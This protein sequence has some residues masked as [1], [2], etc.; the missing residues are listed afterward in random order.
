MGYVLRRLVAFALTLSIAFT[1]A[2]LASAEP[3]TGA[4]TGSVTASD[5]TPIARASV[6]LQGRTSRTQR[7]DQSGRFS[8]EG[9]APGM[10]A[11][12]AGAGEYNPLAP[13]PIEVRAGAPKSIE[14][15]LV[16]S[17]TSLVT[18][19]TVRAA[20][21]TAIST[22]S[23][24]T[25][26]LNTQE[27]AARGFTRIGDVLQDAL[28]ATVIRQGSSSLA[29][30]QSVALRGPDPTETLIDIDGHEV[31]NSSTGDFD[32]ALLDPAD[33]E[34]VQ[35]VYGIAP[36]SLIAPSTIGGAINV[37]TL[38]PTL[39]RHG[40]LRLS[41][42]SFNSFGET[43][44]ETGTINRLGYALSVHRTTTANEV[45]RTM[46]SDPNANM[47][48]V[49]SSVD[50]GTA[51][52]KLR[53]RFGKSGDGYAEFTLRDQS[54]VRD[55]S[56]ALSSIVLPGQAVPGP[57][58]LAAAPPV[59]NS[60]AGSM[61]LDRNA[62]YGFDVQVPLGSHGSEGTARTTALLRHLTSV[63][64]RSVVGPADGLSPYYYNSHDRLSDDTLEIDHNRTNATFALKFRL[65]SERLDTESPATAVPNALSR[66]AQ[67]QGSAALRFTYDPTTHMHYTAAAYYSSFSTFGQSFDPRLGI[68]WTPTA[69]TALRASA[70]T[71]FQAPQLSELFV[72]Q[73][74]PQPDANGHVNIG[75]PNLKADR[76]NEYDIGI[77][78]LFGGPAH[79]THVAADMYR[80]NLRTPSQRF[81]PASTC[82]QG[83]PDLS[84]ASYPI[85]IGNAVYTG[86]ELHVDQMLDPQTVVRVGYGVDSA[87][88]KS[89]PPQ[90]QD[91]TIVPHEQFL[92]VPLHKATL[93]I[94]HRVR[95]G[96]SYNA[97]L[98]YEGRYNELNQPPFTTLRAGLN[99][100]FA[101]NDIGLE[102][103]NITG[104]YN[105][106]FTRGGAGVPYG[107]A[108]GSIATD[109][110]PLQGPAF[111][112]SLTRRF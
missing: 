5:G 88:P 92:G 24:P 112:L 2:R 107:G 38:E 51:L 95:S 86:G 96:I 102:A 55:V 40:L 81:L 108:A 7:V 89:V 67:R 22:S 44:Q 41:A 56:A 106:K 83:A 75:N 3:M 47:S 77:E 82:A 59:F 30:P 63:A 58:G 17:S 37:R 45:S 35:V 62:G 52:A 31:N 54:A 84:C 12:T 105:G 68:V 97:A 39:T 20:G 25:Q 100:S 71:T 48:A 15:I 90:V 111:T 61:L 98:L 28:S 21:A 66:L 13:Q 93:S 79:R 9:L 64:A 57:S 34:S 4:I 18:I 60:F 72:P 76:A 103:T 53:Y 43:F 32:L 74:L 10:Y 46:I 36:S 94:D 19:G 104:V 23:V 87:Y 65:R 1:G 33:F 8:I 69:T 85:N 91:G 80:T 70:G 50:A 42:G 78:H 11:V 29:A 14:L 16:R 26:I 6:T 73:T 99:W 109:A 110:Y 101:N 49:G 27:Y